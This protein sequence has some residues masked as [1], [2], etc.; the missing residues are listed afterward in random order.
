MQLS[1]ISRFGT[2][3]QFLL[4]ILFTPSRLT[5]S[6]LF[7]GGYLLSQHRANKMVSLPRRLLLFDN[8]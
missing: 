3:H 4:L 5:R 2:L 1:A 6:R 7:S 8:M